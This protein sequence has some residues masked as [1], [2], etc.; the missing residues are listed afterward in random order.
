MG[1]FLDICTNSFMHIGIN[2]HQNEDKS[3]F[4]NQNYYAKTI[5]PIQLNKEQVRISQYPLAE[6]ELHQLNS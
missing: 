2:I 1:W 4:F 6:K 5:S 3:I